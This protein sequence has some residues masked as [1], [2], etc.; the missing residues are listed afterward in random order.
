[1]L[2]GNSWVSRRLKGYVNTEIKI[3]TEY[4]RRAFLNW[5]KYYSTI[6]AKTSFSNFSSQMTNK[7]TPVDYPMI[8]NRSQ[9]YYYDIN[10]LNIK[11]FSLQILTDIVEVFPLD[12]PTKTMKSGQRDYFRG[13]QPEDEVMNSTEINEDFPKGNSRTSIPMYYNFV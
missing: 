2:W 13:K 10:C 9:N 5:C 7:N 1:M 11:L 4:W 12:S 6:A 8:D 3:S